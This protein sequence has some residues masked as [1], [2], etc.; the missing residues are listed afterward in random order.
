MSKIKRAFWE[1]ILEAEY[2][3]EKRELNEGGRNGRS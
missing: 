3:R 1:D 2:E